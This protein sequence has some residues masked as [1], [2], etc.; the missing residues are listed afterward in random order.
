MWTLTTEAKEYAAFLKRLHV[1][2]SKLSK[3]HSVADVDV[4]SVESQFILKRTK[5]ITP[6]GFHAESE[7]SYDPPTVAEGDNSGASGTVGVR[8][9]RAKESVGPSYEERLTRKVGAQQRKAAVSIQTSIRRKHETKELEKKKEASVKIQARIRGHNTRQQNNEEGTSSRKQQSQTP[10][11]PSATASVNGLHDNI[12]RTSVAMAKRS[13][14]ESETN[15]ERGQPVNADS[16]GSCWGGGGMGSEAGPSREHLAFGAS[17]SRFDQAT[18]VTGPDYHD[19]HQSTDSGRGGGFGGSGSR[20]ANPD[21]R[22]SGPR[23]VPTDRGRDAD[24]FF[25]ADGPPPPLKPRAVSASQAAS[26]GQRA[27]TSL[28]RM[29]E[30]RP[31]THMPIPVLESSGASPSPRHAHSARTKRPDPMQPLKRRAPLPPQGRD[32]IL[33]QPPRYLLPP[34]WKPPPRRA[35]AARL[36]LVQADDFLA[37]LALVDRVLFVRN[38]GNSSPKGSRVAPALDVAVGE[39]EL[40][41]PKVYSPRYTPHSARSPPTLLRSPRS[42][43]AG[44][45]DRLAWTRSSRQGLKWGAWHGGFYPAAC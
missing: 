43:G 7:P 1:C 20:F 17:S 41:P 35:P 28:S 34:A 14:R 42:R 12:G 38:S 31:S 8:P 26:A 4:E 21:G 18:I 25:D 44:E 24:V 6:S 22:P 5:E 11:S 3:D 19:Y 45:A 13:G 15:D 27:T 36:L 29:G 33:D 40:R 30:R 2:A 10:G 23:D 9:S 16:S 39:S 32:A 37:E